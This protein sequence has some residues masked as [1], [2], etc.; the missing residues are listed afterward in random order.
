MIDHISTYATDYPATRAFYEGALAPLGY[1]LQFEMS[2]DGDGDSPGR[3]ICA[4][5]PTGRP[6]FRIIEVERE[7]SP[8]H[9]AFAAPD[10]ESVSAFYE[11]AL[12]SGGSDNGAP[13]LRPIYH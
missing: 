3:R 12:R 6:V 7:V 1:S 5:G 13:G 8:R 4:F 2:A 10:R 11:V 9:V